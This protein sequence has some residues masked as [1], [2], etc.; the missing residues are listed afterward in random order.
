MAG[1]NYK[2][3]QNLVSKTVLPLTGEQTKVTLRE[4]SSAL[5]DSNE[6][7]DGPATTPTTYNVTATVVKI[8]RRSGDEKK[9]GE[10]KLLVPGDVPKEPKIGWTVLVW[11]VEYRVVDMEVTRPGT[12][13]LLYGL[14]CG[15]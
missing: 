7:Q 1:V 3:I 4:P 11:N 8:K 6:P 14:I 2:Q 15:R 13:T 12:T 10:F 9:Q 5:F